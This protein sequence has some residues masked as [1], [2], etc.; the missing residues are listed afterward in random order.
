MSIITP[1]ADR[2]SVEP[3]VVVSPSELLAV[4]ACA[5][6]SILAVDNTV[7]S[8][9]SAAEAH[10]DDRAAASLG[11]ITL[12]AI[13]QSAVFIFAVQAI[14]EAVAEFVLENWSENV[15]VIT[16]EAHRS[17]LKRMCVLLGVAVKKV[18]LLGVGG[19]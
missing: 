9:R 8:T 18:S 10:A 11:F 19:C 3:S 2:S 17:W 13:S 5:E 7:R 16:M 15:H 12:A 4:A 6:V 14:S 1:A